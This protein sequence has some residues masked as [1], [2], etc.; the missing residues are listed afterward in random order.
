MPDARLNGIRLYYEQ[1]GEGTPILCIHGTS[2]SALVWGEAVATLARLGR[3]IV[4]DR[5]GH[6]R[7]ERP[8]AYERTS[9]SKHA[10]DAA[11][12]L[13]GLRATPAIVIGRSYGGPSRSSSRDATPTASEHSSCSNRHP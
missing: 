4:Y 7:S 1:Q 9:V 6:T 8:E 11:A 5:R 12:L 3:V 13:D 10:D 2:S